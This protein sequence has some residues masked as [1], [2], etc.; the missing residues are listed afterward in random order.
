MEKSSRWRGLEDLEIQ[1]GHGVRWTG[2]WVEIRPEGVGDDVAPAGWTSA[3][4]ADEASD[5]CEP[6]GSP[7]PG[8]VALGGKDGDNLAEGQ[9]LGAERN[10]AGDDGPFGVV[11]NE[12]PRREGGVSI[13]NGA[14]ALTPGPAG[15]ERRSGARSDEGSL[16]GRRAVDDRTH[17]LIRGTV[18]VAY[19]IGRDNTRTSTGDGA[20]DGRGD[21][22]VSG[23]AVPAGDDKDTRVEGGDVREGVVQGGAV[24]KFARAAD[25][26]VGVPGRDRDLGALGPPGD[27]RPLGLGPEVLLFGGHPEVGHG[28]FG[29]P[30]STWPHNPGPYTHRTVCVQ[31]LANPGRAGRDFLPRGSPEAGEDGG[32]RETVRV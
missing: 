3:G 10:D 14:R 28:Q 27:E 9:P 18:P 13:G 26:G 7:D 30:G 21:N 23:K 8:Y 29:I 19:A 22:N 25:T 20:G 6:E 24:A 16:V 31:K 1:P 2:S 4:G 32:Q 17:E 5:L 12:G 11:W 15:L